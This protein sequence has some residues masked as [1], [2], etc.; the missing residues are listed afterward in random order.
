[1][2]KRGREEERRGSERDGDQDCEGER[3]SERYESESGDDGESPRLW[4][5]REK[6]KMISM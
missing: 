3:V 2:R 4:K 1:M 5:K 6:K